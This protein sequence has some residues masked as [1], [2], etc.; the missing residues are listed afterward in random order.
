MEPL[1][2]ATFFRPGEKAIHFR[3]CEQSLLFFR[4]SERN[5]RARERRSR[6]RRETRAAAREEKRYFLIKKKNLVNMVNGQVFKD[7]NSGIF[8]NFTPFNTATYSKFRKS[9]CV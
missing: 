7:S 5:A 1:L 4:F 6:E 8:Y 3:D 2:T 9:K